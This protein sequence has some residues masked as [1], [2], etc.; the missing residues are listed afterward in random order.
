MSWHVVIMLIFMQLI[1]E[2][3]SFN[4]RKLPQPPEGTTF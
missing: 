1:R 3:A 2:M 4:N